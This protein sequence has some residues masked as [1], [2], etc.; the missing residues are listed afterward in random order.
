MTLSYF[1]VFGIWREIYG[2]VRSLAVRTDEI[3]SSCFVH[4]ST[5]AHAPVREKLEEE[6]RQPRTAGL[7]WTGGPLIGRS[8][9]L[10][11]FVIAGLPLLTLR[12]RFPA[13]PYR[14]DMRIRET[15][16]L[17]RTARAD[18]APFAWRI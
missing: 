6:G 16:L 14:L 7:V 2:S 5:T 12:Q 1:F 10:R 15:V 8:W 18:E 17:V 11:E 13:L 9:P 3:F 4:A